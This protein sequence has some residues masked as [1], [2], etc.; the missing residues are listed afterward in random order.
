MSSNVENSEQGQVR[1]KCFVSVIA[2]AS[3]HDAPGPRA[4]DIHLDIMSTGD[5]HILAS[6]GPYHSL[7]G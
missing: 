2:I 1:G 6:Y 4:L 7:P 5:E 3:L